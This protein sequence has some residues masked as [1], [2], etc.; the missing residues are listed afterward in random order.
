MSLP[1]V[2][3]QI[4]TP[5]TE[6]LVR[7]QLLKCHILLHKEEPLYLFPGRGAAGLWVRLRIYKWTSGEKLCRILP[8]PVAPAEPAHEL[9]PVPST[10]DKKYLK[11]EI[12]F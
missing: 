11:F 8:P 7:P 9:E 5:S 1:G 6:H 4:S 3:M 10:A 2:A 12:S